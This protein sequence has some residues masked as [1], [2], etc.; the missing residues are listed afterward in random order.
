MPVN[1][2]LNK[3][4]FSPVIAQQNWFF[5]KKGYDEARMIQEQEKKLLKKAN[6][7][8]GIKINQPRFVM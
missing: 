8:R 5:A 7:T 1:I 2:Q 6:A 4:P 3:P